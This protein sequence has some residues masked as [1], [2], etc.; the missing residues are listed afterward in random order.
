MNCQIGN[1]TVK[2]DKNGKLASIISSKQVVGNSGRIVTERLASNIEFNLQEIVEFANRDKNLS[3]SSIDE[4]L[5]VNANTLK[6]IFRKYY[7]N[8]YRNIHNTAANRTGN[9]LKGFS[10]QEALNAAVEYVAHRFVARKLDSNAKTKQEQINIINDIRKEL[11]EEFDTM[12]DNKLELIKAD[13]KQLPTIVK[14]YYE[15]IEK[16]NSLID[17]MED[18]EGDELKNLEKQYDA[19]ELENNS[20]IFEIIKEFGTI[21]EQNLTALYQQ[22]ETNPYEFFDAVAR[23]SIVTKSSRILS[24]VVSEDIY[25]DNNIDAEDSNDI[26]NNDHDSDETA[27]WNKGS[28]ANSYTKLIDNEFRNYISTHLAKLATP[29]QYGSQTQNYVRNEL[30]GT[31]E[32]Y[33]GDELLNNLLKQAEN[34]SNIKDIDTFV[35]HLENLSTTQAYFYGIGALV[36]RMKNDI[37]FKYFVYRNLSHFKVEKFI[38]TS[39]KDRYS[40]S[41]SNSSAFVESTEYNKFFNSYRYNFRNIVPDDS[42]VVGIDF[43]DKTIAEDKI[44]LKNKIT[45]LFNI[46]APAYPLTALYN[47]IDNEIP[48]NLVKLNN[49]INV[50]YD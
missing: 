23:T 44:T 34:T 28:V 21:I 41:V 8:K 7:F 22:S 3:I 42:R 35:A 25:D 10:S 50:L 45:K 39:D 36:D 30:L 48:Y 20:T 14:T 6:S 18:K 16:L 27:F 46:I 49:N 19:L 11:R 12:F 1:V 31:I 32:Y 38:V 15:Q 43:K 4:L 24:D 2:G 47:Y 26:T 5:D 37:E 9:D 40:I 33:D 17:E 29:Y 13:N